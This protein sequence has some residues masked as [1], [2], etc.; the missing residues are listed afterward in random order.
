MTAAT[1]EAAIVLALMVLLYLLPT[2][3]AFLRGKSVFSVAVVNIFGGW[4]G[5]GWL[6]A[7]VMAAR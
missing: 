5:I 1:I 7:L 2:E 6:V 4:T 3:I